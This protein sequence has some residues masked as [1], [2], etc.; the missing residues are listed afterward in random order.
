MS[1]P[2]PESSAPEA[3]A[4]EVTAP[5]PPR[6]TMRARAGDR[7]RLRP[8]AAPRDTPEMFHGVYHAVTAND[9]AL[10]LAALAGRYFAAGEA[11]RVALPDGRAFDV[12]AEGVAP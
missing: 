4:G 8:A 10:D 12:T 5:P 1:D 3:S 6:L 9:P 2:A 7:I 11:V